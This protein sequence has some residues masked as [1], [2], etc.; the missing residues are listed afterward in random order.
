MAAPIL[1][2]STDSGAST[3]AGVAGELLTVLN[4]CLICRMVFTSTDLAGTT[5]LVDNTTKA[6]SQSTGANAGTW[7][8]FQTGTPGA[9]TDACF[10]GMTAKFGR[11]KFS[12]STPGTSVAGFTVEYWNGSAWTAVAG[13]ADGTSGLT[14][15][16]TI[17]WTIPSDWATTALNGITVYWIRLRYTSYSVMP[18]VQYCTVT[19]WTQKYGPTSNE[20]AYQQGGGNTFFLDIEDN[21][22]SNT[23]GG[24]GAPTARDA[25]VY[26]YETMSAVKVGTQMT[27]ATGTISVWRKSA[28]ADATTRPWVVA[29]DDR[30]VYLFAFAGDTSTPYTAAGAGE[31]YSMLPADPYRFMVL[32]NVAETAGALSTANQL[33]ANLVGS[34]TTQTGKYAMRNYL[35]IG[36]PIAISL[37]GD[38]RF[39]NNGISWAGAI[40]YPNGP[41]GGMWVVPIVVAEL[42]LLN[43]RGRLRG[44]SYPAQATLNFTDGDTVAGANA[45]AG[46]TFLCLKPTVSSV[47]ITGIFLVETSDTWETN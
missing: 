37:L 22:A 5:G 11:A 46:K 2:R 38:A 12:L 34:I 35:G 36:V 1:F 9:A 18:I 25:R 42:S 14:A 41:D 27:P 17:T 6:R 13:L 32:S 28:S 24:A 21:G 39:G 7:L 31:F 15:S 40:Q 45:Y 3:L 8:P 26:G 10:I 33:M 19:G 29:A 4:A 47:G 43:I 30:T 20:I 16:G 23:Q 44:L